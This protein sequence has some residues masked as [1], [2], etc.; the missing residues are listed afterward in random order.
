MSQN[1]WNLS[2]LAAAKLLLSSLGVECDDEVGR[3]ESSTG[4]KI[5]LVGKTVTNTE[6]V[7]S[8]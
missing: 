3:R 4:C 7:V 6:S 5:I 1:S 2:L 8:L